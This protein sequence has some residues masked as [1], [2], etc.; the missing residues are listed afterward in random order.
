[1]RLAINVDHVATLRNARKEF[2]PDPVAAAL[3]AEKAGADGIVVH[4]REDR[5]HINE[6]DVRI[7]RQVISTK[8]DLEMAAI[9]EIIKIACD[10]KPEL[11]TIV[12][13]KRMELTTE[14]GL[15]VIDNITNLKET[16]QILHKHNIE[17]SLFI[18]PEI[19]QID[20]S[21]EI[22]ADFIEIHTG[23]FANCSSEEE[24]FDELERIRNAAKHAKKLGLGVNA[25]HGLNYQNIKV[26]REIKEID[27]VSIGHAIIAKAIM[28]G[29]EAAVR[30]MRDL[31]RFG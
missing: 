24:Q 21:A 7:L 18:E 17:V 15:N 10:V 1:M 29:M 31:I 12:P 11:A 25:G 2:L 20:A 13:E 26:F 22:G 28:V 9:D 5:R 23:I 19:N 27:E 4:L 16:I 6:R 3:A 30:E 8:L 14:G